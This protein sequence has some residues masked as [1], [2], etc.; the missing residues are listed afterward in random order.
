M[1]LNQ[2]LLGLRDRLFDGLKLLGDVMAR[3]TVLNHLDD[4]A[5]VT[6]RALEPL[7][8]LGMGA[9][10]VLA[11]RHGLTSYPPGGDMQVF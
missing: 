9:M 3:A 8:D 7:D 11:C 2:R 4:A 1:V 10:D 5:Q 6:V